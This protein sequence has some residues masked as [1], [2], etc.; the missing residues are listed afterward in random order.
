MIIEGIVVAGEVVGEVVEAVAEVTVEAAEKTAEVAAEVGEKVG[1]VAS[2][3][4][5]KIADTAEKTGEKVAEVTGKAKEGIEY[6]VKETQSKSIE[7][8]NPGDGVKTKLK[9]IKQ[10]TPEQLR[11]IMNQ[12]LEKI[13]RNKKNDEGIKKIGDDSNENVR[14]GLT[15]GQKTRIKEETGWS[16]EIIDSINSCEEYQIYKGADLQEVEIGGKKCLIRNDIDWDKKWE[17][18]KYDENGNPK[19]ETNQER[20]SMGKAPLDENGN[21]IQLHHIGQHIDSPLAELTFEEH[22]CNGNDTILHDKTKETETHGEGNTWDKER[23]DYWKNRVE[24]YVKGEN[25]NV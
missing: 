20:M 23:Q 2:E 17:T 21:P 9:D 6:K 15:E 3:V 4:G 12:N 10:N 7:V 8:K 5:K 25:N 19:Y 22:R 18:G 14:E 16:D 24:E 13:E 1:E 11:E